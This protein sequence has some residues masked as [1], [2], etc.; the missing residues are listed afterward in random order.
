MEKQRKS[1]GF[2]AFIGPLQSRL[3]FSIRPM[4]TIYECNNYIRWN[5]NFAFWWIPKKQLFHC[6]YGKYFAV[7]ATEAHRRHRGAP[8]PPRRTG[9]NAAH[10]RHL[11]AP[12]PTRRTGATAAHGRNPAA[13]CYLGQPAH[14]L[15][16]PTQALRLL[17]GGIDAPGWHQCAR[18]HWLA[19]WCH[20]DSVH[21]NDT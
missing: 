17:L 16:C 1:S 19:R 11:G 2:A 9:A 8:A 3:F 18:E 13:Q 7:I 6:N 12:A 5:V 4:Q 20:C 10:R 15:Q 14:L 21:C